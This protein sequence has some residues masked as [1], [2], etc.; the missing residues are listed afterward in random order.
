[1]LLMCVLLTGLLQMACGFLQLAKLVQ[2]IPQPAMLGFMNGLGI[3][4]FMAQV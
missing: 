3:V 2:L 4:I 1:M